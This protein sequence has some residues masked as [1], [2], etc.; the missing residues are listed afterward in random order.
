[1]PRGFK[2]ARGGSPGGRPKRSK[3][4]RRSGRRRRRM[5]TGGRGLVRLIRRVAR[6]S[7]ETKYDS[8][9][10]GTSFPI[11]VGVSSVPV[12]VTPSLWNAIPVGDEHNNR[13]G[14]LVLIKSLKLRLT[15]RF[16]SGGDI[17]NHVRVIV[18]WCP[19]EELI[20]VA[21][22]PTTNGT[23]P[24]TIL[25]WANQYPVKVS[26]AKRFKILY[27]KTVYISNVNNLSVPSSSDRAFLRR[28]VNISINKKQLYIS[29]AVAR[30]RM[31]MFTM[32]DS[33]IAPHPLLYGNYKYFWKDA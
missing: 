30:G 9:V 21:D 28:Q 25:A 3:R 10:T 14:D 2:R 31:Q 33:L 16:A 26:R 22:L 4:G 6:D 11:E 18:T 8:N 20:T 32:S 23:A 7:G 19:S 13:D 24:S 5:P 15:F 1:M 17:Y 12:D 27:D 29:G